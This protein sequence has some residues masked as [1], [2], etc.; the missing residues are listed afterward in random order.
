MG[1]DMYMKQ[2]KRYSWIDIKKKE[3]YLVKKM[4]VTIEREFED[5]EKRVDVIEKE[6]PELFEKFNS[7]TFWERLAICLMNKKIS[8]KVRNWSAYSESRN[9]M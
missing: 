9:V 2:R 4:K 3:N 5:G 8:I 7:L 1:L 6:N